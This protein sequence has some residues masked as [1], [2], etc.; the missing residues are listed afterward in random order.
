MV[1]ALWGFIPGETLYLKSVSGSCKALLGPG[2]LAHDLKDGFLRLFKIASRIS[3]LDF[4]KSPPGALE[5]PPVWYHL[6]VSFKQIKSNIIFSKMIILGKM[7][8]GHL[9]WTHINRPP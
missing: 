3:S 4:L 5:I 9:T 6:D 2:K 7:E 1:F 8:Q